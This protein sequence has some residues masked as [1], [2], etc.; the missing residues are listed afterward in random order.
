MINSSPLCDK[1]KVDD[2]TTEATHHCPTC[3]LNYCALHLQ[4][5]NQATKTKD[6]SS[7]VKSLNSKL[8]DFCRREWKEEIQAHY[9]CSECQVTMCDIHKTLHNSLKS[10]SIHSN[11]VKMIGSNQMP[12]SN[13]F[14]LSEML[15]DHEDVIFNFRNPSAIEVDTKNS[16]IYVIDTKANDIVVVYVFDLQSKK[17]KNTF[18]LNEGHRYYITTLAVD[19]NDN[20]LLYIYDG[21]VVKISND[22][23]TTFWKVFIDGNASN[24]CVHPSDSTVYVLSQYGKHVVTVLSGE[25]GSVL[26]EIGESTSGDSILSYPHA[27]AFDH[28]GNLV[29]AC[30]LHEGT[31]M[32]INLKGKILKKITR[33]MNEDGLVDKM[34]VEPVT[35]IIMFI[36]RKAVHTIKTNGTQKKEWNQC[37]KSG[38]KEWTGFDARLCLALNPLDGELLVSCNPCDYSYANQAGVFI[39]K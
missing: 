4:F 3:Q 6:H 12:F 15:G 1:C 17:L 28:E 10:R 34:V 32:T 9:E 37:G 29:V 14:K 16:N 7:Q 39:Y 31:F 35:G 18:E 33:G 27:L 11:L 25:D 20:A 5:H 30:G 19:P 8:C 21:S 22:G 24:L 13:Q 36:S 2:E 38:E 23:S 26:R